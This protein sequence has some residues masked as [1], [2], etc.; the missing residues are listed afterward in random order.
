MLSPSKTTAEPVST[1]TSPRDW[2]LQRLLVAS[3]AGLAAV[4]ILVFGASLYAMTIHATYRQAEAD[5]LGAAQVL[6]QDLETHHDATALAISELYANRFGKAPRDHAYYAV[7]DE[8]GRLLAASNQLPAHSVRSATPPPIRGPRPFMAVAHGIYL[9]VIVATP[10]H[11]QLLIG[12]PLA[13][14]FDALGWAAARLLVVG[15]ICLVMGTAVAVW[16]ARQIAR[17][18]ENIS[19]TAE[20]ISSRNLSERL[21]AGHTPREITRLAIVM[22][23]MLDSLKEAFDQQVRFTADASHELRTPVSVVLSQADFTLSRDRSPEQYREALETCLQS[24]RRMK[25]LVDDLLL[26]SRADSGRLCLRK[27]P[28]DLRTVVEDAIQL[29]GPLAANKLIR[30]DRQ[31]SSVPILGDADRLGQVVTNL[32]TNSISYSEP[33][34]SV[35]VEVFESTDGAVLLVRDEGFGIPAEDQPHLFE[36]F[37]RVDRARSQDAENGTGLG[38]SLVAEIIAA[39]GGTIHVDSVEGQGTT[40]T[41]HLPQVSTQSPA[42]RLNST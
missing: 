22:N 21:P 12:R 8:E 37:Y 25:K 11:G 2:T 38:L 3:H 4:V 5:L 27:D 26:L 34:R 16:L 31:L 6:V 24:A 39:H 36:R 19:D 9:D 1:G 35:R 28:I 10:R 15:L 7:W 33:N 29:L 30:I 17:P 14:E 23:Q 41:I 20:R 40:M 13:K 18:I 42:H 32:V